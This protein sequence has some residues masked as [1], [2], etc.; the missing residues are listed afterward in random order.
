[1]SF[2][3]SKYIPLQD[4]K[5]QVF[6]GG[7][8]DNSQ[9]WMLPYKASPFARNFRV[10]GRGISP[11]LG[12]SRI[13]TLWAT[14][15]ATWAAAY[16]RQNPTNDQ[17]IARYNSDGT[18]KLVSINPV[19]YAVTPVTTAALIASDNKM[20]FL[21]A[22]D[23]IY[24][25]NGADAFGKLNG[26]TYTNP[27]TGIAGFKPGFAAWFDNSMFCGGD[28]AF[29]Y[30]LYKSAENNADSF[31]GTGS[32]IFDGS[33]PLTWLASAWQ[34]LYVFSE[35]Q[36]DMINNNSIKQIGSSLV[37]TSIPLEANEGAVNHA[38]IAVV[39]KDC[40]YLTRSNKIKKVVPNGMLYYDVAEVSHRPNAGIDETM[41]LLDPDQSLGCSYVL[42]DKWLVKWFLKTRWSTY[43]DICIVYS[44]IYDE[45]M[46]DTNHVF[47][48]ACWY[49][50]KSFAFAQVEPKMYLDEYGHTYDD[51]AIP[52]V[53]YTKEVTLWDP[54]IN[55]ELWQSRLF[56]T[57][58]YDTEMHERILG[59]S[60]LLNEKILDSSMLPVLVWGIGTREVGTYPMG[61]DWNVDPLAQARLISVVEKW[62]L[63]YRCK[64]F[65]WEYRCNSLGAD[66]LLQMLSPRI[67]MVSEKATSTH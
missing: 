4:K 22:A 42:P 54:T 16:I 32:D 28:P 44:F 1:M 66:F 23:S 30:R 9:P 5:G 2:A 60:T 3:T 10:N 7:I 14:G 36:I 65:Q 67:E 27:A 45:F 49:K 41:R 29:P 39:G 57:M 59:D 50:T 13:A 20:N 48:A 64:Y 34:T 53:Y 47:S 61:E 62:D 18:H 19:T 55:K 43:N 24:C 6:L 8:I 46:V 31:S 11:A 15:A 40:F 52:F 38:T 17:I 33:Y 58:N 56:M 51:S 26:S 12:F 37:Y 25:M 21:N 63:Q 35:Q